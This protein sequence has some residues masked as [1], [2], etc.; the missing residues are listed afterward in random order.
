MVYGK[1]MVWQIFAPVIQYIIHDE[2]I[3]HSCGRYNGI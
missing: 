2:E 1:L 3:K